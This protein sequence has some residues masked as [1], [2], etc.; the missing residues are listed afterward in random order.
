MYKIE[1]L[2]LKMSSNSHYTC[3]HCHHMHLKLS[4]YDVLVMMYH[5]GSILSEGIAVSNCHFRL[6]S[7]DNNLV[8]GTAEKH[9]PCST[10]PACVHIEMHGHTQCDKE[11]TQGRTGAQY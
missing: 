9:L 1:E 2:I 11:T 10:H 6:S 8:P 5:F 4:E 7:N 3:F